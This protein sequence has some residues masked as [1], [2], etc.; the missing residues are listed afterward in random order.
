[1]KKEE[2]AAKEA[3]DGTSFAQFFSGPSW[4]QAGAVL[5]VLGV[6]CHDNY[7]P[8]DAMNPS[9]QIRPSLYFL[10]S[11]CRSC[12]NQTCVTSVSVRTAK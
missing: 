8:K 4:R 11:S 6:P 12:F 10:R 2:N 5:L 9:N 7:G 1:M 3:L